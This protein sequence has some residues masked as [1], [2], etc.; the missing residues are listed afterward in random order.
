MAQGFGMHHILPQRNIIDGSIE[1]M[2]KAHVFKGMVML[3]L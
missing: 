2:V 3:A 1:A